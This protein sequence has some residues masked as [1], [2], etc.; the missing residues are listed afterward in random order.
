M[1]ASRL[2]GRMNQFIGQDL[3]D[4][5]LESGRDVRYLAFIFVGMCLNVA[6]DGGF[7]AAETEIKVGFVEIGS[8]ETR[9]F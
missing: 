7:D 8:G 1:A 4:R 3:Y 5:C 9:F 6:F 2:F